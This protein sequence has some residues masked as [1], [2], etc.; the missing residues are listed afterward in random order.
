MGFTV[1]RRSTTSWKRKKRIH[2]KI[3]FG[4]FFHSF[5][6]PLYT[7]TL[8]R[9]QYAAANSK[10]LVGRAAGRPNDMM[11]YTREIFSKTDRP[12]LVT[13]AWL[14]RRFG[15]RRWRRRPFRWLASRLA[16]LRRHP[17]H[18]RPPDTVVFRRSSY[19]RP[20]QKKRY[21]FYYYFNVFV[22][23]SVLTYR[24]ISVSS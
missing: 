1:C 6:R 5:S 2:R 21:L 7:T 15:N 14:H 10:Q 22:F 9:Y 8:P 16:P 23:S 4:F 13:F 12:Q 17:A 18:W 3:W 20:F 24:F 11:L 19:F